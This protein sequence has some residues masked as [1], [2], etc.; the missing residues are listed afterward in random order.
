MAIKLTIKFRSD[1]SSRLVVRNVD[2][3]CSV[4]RLKQLISPFA[5]V[6]AI[7][8]HLYF[9]LVTFHFYLPSNLLLTLISFQ[10]EEKGNL[11]ALSSS[12]LQVTEIVFLFRIIEVETPNQAAVLIEELSGKNI[13]G[14]KIRLQRYSI[15]FF[16]SRSN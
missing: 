4:E 3:S 13:N 2:H 6:R 9:P 7:G 16:R 11:N 14:S 1:E 8:L 12:A 15:S 5:S 10:I